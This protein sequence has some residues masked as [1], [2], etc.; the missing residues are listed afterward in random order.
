M[1]VVMEPAGEE[2]WPL[3]SL[4]GSLTVHLYTAQES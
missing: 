3:H 1:E 4:K 2:H